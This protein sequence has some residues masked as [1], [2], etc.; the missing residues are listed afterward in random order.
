[1]MTGLESV[2]DAPTRRP[3]DPAAKWQTPETQLAIALKHGP[4]I[5]QGVVPYSLVGLLLN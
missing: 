1:M 2:S 3:T 4:L 5:F